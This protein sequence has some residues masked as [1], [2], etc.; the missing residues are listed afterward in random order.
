MATER[1]SLAAAA[2]KIGVLLPLISV[3]T[4]GGSGAARSWLD[5]MQTCANVDPVEKLTGHLPLPP[6][7]IGGWLV[8]WS[9][10]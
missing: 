4:R 10:V 2:A 5:H 7:R 3:A 6:L 9:R 1:N 8:G